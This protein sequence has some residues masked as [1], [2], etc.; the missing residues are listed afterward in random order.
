MKAQA[1]AIVNGLSSIVQELKRRA[2]RPLGDFVE[3]PPEQQLRAEHE[4]AEGDAERRGPRGPR[5]LRRAPRAD[6]PDAAEDER[7]RAEEN[8]EVRDEPVSHKGEGHRGRPALFNWRHRKLTPHAWPRRRR[9]A[10][11]GRAT[12][13]GL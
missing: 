4:E 3:E 9:R 13:D 12:T 7:A 10:V 2:A 1:Q 11:R 6:E 5:V 8:P